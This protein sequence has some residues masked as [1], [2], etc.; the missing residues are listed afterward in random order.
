MKPVDKNRIA[1]LENTAGHGFNNGK[2]R[3]FENVNPNDG[4]GGWAPSPRTE[5]DASTRR[6][7]ADRSRL[8]WT[9]ITEARFGN[10]CR[11]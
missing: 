6:I 1:S 8:A 2:L 10:K 3:P 5:T 4:T 11:N 7:L 9:R